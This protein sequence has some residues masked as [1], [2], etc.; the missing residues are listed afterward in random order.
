MKH[1]AKKTSPTPPLVIEAGG[2]LE[3]LDKVLRG[4]PGENEEARA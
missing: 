3:A 2:P 4:G 1:R